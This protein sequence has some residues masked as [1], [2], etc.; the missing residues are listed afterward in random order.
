MAAPERW[1]LIYLSLLSLN[2]WTSAFNLDT[3]NVIKKTGKPSSLFGFSLAMHWQRKPRDQKMLLVGAP[4]AEGLPNQKATITG[5]LYKCP[6]TAEEND[7]VRVIFDDNADLTQESK[8]NQWMGVSVRS[9]GPG[10]K[11]MV[12]AHRYELRRYVN[13]PDEARDVTGQ[14]YVLSQDLVFRENETDKNVKLCVGRLRGH[15]KFGICQQGVASAFSNN[16]TYF[17]Y[18]APGAYNWK[19]IVH[20]EE[21]KNIE[22]LNFDGPYEVGD[23][24]KR[25]E[26]LIPVPA[27]SYLGFS[28][29]SGKGITSKKTFT[30]V[31]GAPRANHAGAVVFLKIEERT[32]NL[33][34]E[35]VLD[36][37]GLA[38]SFGYDVAVVDLNQD[39]WLDLVVGA[40]QF[41]DRETGIGGAAYVYINQ[42][43]NWKNIQPIRLNGTKDSM[44]GLAVENIGDI[45]QDGYPDIAV[46]A[47]YEENGK[48]YIYHG[49]SSG[50]N[51]E[52]SQI[53]DGNDVGIPLFGYSLAGNLDVDANKYPDLAV[54]SLSDVVVMYRARPVIQITKRVTT[55]PNIIDMKKSYCRN[56]QGFCMSVEACFMYTTH[57]SGFNSR[58]IVNYWIEADTARHKMG[59]KPRVRFISPGDVSTNN[60]TGSLILNMQGKEK[61]V[62]KE[63]QLQE[64]IYDILH[65]IPISVGVLLKQSRRKKRQDSNLIDLLPVL[66]KSDPQRTQVEFLKEGCGSDGICKSNLK[67]EYEFCSRDQN[68]QNNFIPLPKDKTIP[69]FKLKDQ[70]DIGLKITVTNKPSDPKRP[71]EDGDDAHEAHLTATFPDTLTYSTYRP[72]TSNSD[73]I[74]CTANQNGSQAV[75]DLGNP[76]KRGS[77]VVFY[78]V[79]STAGITLDT[80]NLNINLQLDTTSEQANVSTIASAQVMIEL[81]LSLVGAA[82]PS[83]VYFGGSPIGESAM[84]T[85]EDIGSLIQYEFRIIHL[86]TSRKTLNNTWLQIRWPKEINNGKW[87]LYL[88]KIDS[89]GIDNIK[90]M[91]ENEINNQ[92]LREVPNQIRKRRQLEANGPKK[93]RITLSPKRKYITLDCDQMNTTRCVDI[94]CPLQGLDSSAFLVLRSRLWNTTFLE[95]FSKLNYLDIIVKATITAESQAKNIVINNAETKVR[96][97]V[98]PE[99]TENHYF[100]VPWWIVFV[101]IL[102]GILL[103]AL[104]VFLLWKCG[105]F[106]RSHYDDSVPRYHAVR[107]K[108]EERQTFEDVKLNKKFDKKQWMTTW[109]ENESYS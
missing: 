44:F 11:V 69:V 23:E 83:Q 39:S 66:E 105:F 93:S 65:P 104:L 63:L 85:E 27:N 45:N 75:C 19:G 81:L 2:K 9:Q 43:G 103:L 25:D 62:N 92:N 38:S 68:Q 97:T 56:N 98:F 42:E 72:L 82:K 60:V 108:K 29:D 107:I 47:P 8:E 86:G 90:C 7:C 32:R 48:V 109:Q 53:L 61:C 50:I 55:T 73:K 28:L 13:K 87:L 30:F 1:L 80:R 57:P 100:G 52:P 21:I 101:A 24:S 78:L 95:E 99:K 54:G 16:G 34:T 10:G 77:E 49:S 26:K 70:K 22:E 17:V 46:G 59:R 3:E 91:P 102:V 94:K 4:K 35:H 67:L 51:T 74:L 89:K 71:E 14:C 5:G 40:P 18:G 37:E 88:V 33:M 20:V 12:C 15:E 58:I 31:S 79:M 96:V 64:P 6:I 76:L 106:K 41:F 84:K 36:G